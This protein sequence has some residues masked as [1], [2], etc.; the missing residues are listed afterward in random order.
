MTAASASMPTILHMMSM[1]ST[2]LGALEDYMLELVRLCADKG[3]RSMLQYEELPRST[4]YLARL[5][6]AGAQLI[7]TPVLSRPSQRGRAIVNTWE[8]MRK[9]RPAILQTHF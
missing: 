7:V 9:A 4:E 5:D 6:S 2:K 1:R 8:L 3:Y